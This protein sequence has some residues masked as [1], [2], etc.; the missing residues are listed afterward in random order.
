MSNGQQ[1]LDLG[2]LTLDNPQSL[3]SQGLLLF[4]TIC[5]LV[6]TIF[7]SLA[8]YYAAHPEC[9]SL[10]AACLATQCLTSLLALE[11]T[12]HRAPER[13][14]PR[15]IIRLSKSA[16][17]LSRLTGQTFDFTPWTSLTPAELDAVSPRPTPNPLSGYRLR[18]YE[19]NLPTSGN[20]PVSLLP[21]PGATLANV[22][23][24][25]ARLL[26]PDFTP[27]VHTPAFSPSPS[28]SPSQSQSLS[29]SSSSLPSIPSLPSLPSL[30]SIHSIP[31][32]PTLFTSFSVPVP[33]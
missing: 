6:T 20:H 30:P 18:P 33:P 31:P 10:R 11:Y 23:K 3:H 22:I 5:R 26:P 13:I 8:R 9:D 32:A 15:Q 17:L 14:I 27:D 7:S 29:L 1:T 2:H 19:P 4:A 24:K 28:P 25:L 12:L 21:N 16:R